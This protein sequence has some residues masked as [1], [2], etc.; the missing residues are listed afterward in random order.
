MQGKEGE[1]GG[2]ILRV[3]SGRLPRHQRENFKREGGRGYFAA[4]A[5]VINAQV[6]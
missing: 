1:T 3:G 5:N 2:I 4:A 6:Q